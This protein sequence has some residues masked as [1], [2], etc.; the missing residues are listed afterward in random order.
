MQRKPVA[1]QEVG[2][3]KKKQ[4]NQEGVRCDAVRCGAGGKDSNDALCRAGSVRGRKKRERERQ[5]VG[6]RGGVGLWRKHDHFQA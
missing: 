4:E 2:A 3:N 5:R 6:E 1:E